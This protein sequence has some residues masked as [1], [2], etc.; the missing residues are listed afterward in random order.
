MRGAA[1]R[2]GGERR[3]G[4]REFESA[5]AGGVSVEV[6]VAAS[7]AFA[8][9]TFLL[10]AGASSGADNAARTC[11]RGAVGARVVDGVGNLG[12]KARFDEKNDRRFLAPEAGA[13]GFEGA[14]IDLERMQDHSRGVASYVC[15]Y[16]KNA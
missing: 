13:S 10:L 6:G 8:R 5:G 4:L 16:Y 9:G 15:T 14:M 12:I 2:L 7:G 3:R 11:A 1:A